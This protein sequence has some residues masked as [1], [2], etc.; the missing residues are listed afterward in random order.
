MFCSHSRN[1]VDNNVGLLLEHDRHIHLGYDT[2]VSLE[3]LLTALD[4][5]K[6]VSRVAASSLVDEDANQLVGRRSGLVD[7]GHV[8]SNF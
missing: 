6:I 2:V 4:V 5:G 7:L 1:F 3:P 8:V